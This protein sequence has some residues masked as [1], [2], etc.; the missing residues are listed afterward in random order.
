MTGGDVPDD[1][2]EW[3]RAGIPHEDIEAWRTWRIGPAEARLWRGAGVTDA[4][5]LDPAHRGLY[6]KNAS[7]TAPKMFAVGAR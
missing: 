4:L 2:R 3:A 6:S 5:T 1:R 7:S